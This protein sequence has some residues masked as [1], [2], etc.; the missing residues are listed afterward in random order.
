LI[1]LLGSNE[2]FID[3]FWAAILGGIIPVP[4]AGGI[5][6]EHRQKLLR[7]ARRL[8]EPFIYTERRALERIEAS[9]AESGQGETA[10]RLR[11]RALLVDDVT[12]IERAGTVHAARPEDVA[13][14]QFSSGSTREPRGWS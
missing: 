14:I 7:I 4:V 5:S 11:R 2:Q 6:Q 10:E 9:A 3:G 13:F 12:E 8:G 1:L